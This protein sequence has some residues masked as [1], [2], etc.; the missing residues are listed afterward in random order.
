MSFLGSKALRFPSPTST[1]K[2]QQLDIKALSLPTDLRLWESTTGKTPTLTIMAWD[3]DWMKGTSR[4]HKS[5]QRLARVSREPFQ[6]ES[7]EISLEPPRQLLTLHKARILEFLAPHRPQ[8]LL[9]LAPRYRY[10]VILDIEWA[11]EHRTS[12]VNPKETVQSRAK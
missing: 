11:T 6:L 4:I 5:L 12:M 10:P 3:L 1:T 7:T 8:L 9:P 2:S